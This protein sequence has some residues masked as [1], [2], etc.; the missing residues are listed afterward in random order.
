MLRRAFVLICVLSCTSCALKQRIGQELDRNPLKIQGRYEMVSMDVSICGKFG[1]LPVKSAQEAGVNEVVFGDQIP[2]VK[3]VRQFKAQFIDP[4]LGMQLININDEI[5][6][7][8]NKIRLKSA[9]ANVYG[10]LK[11]S[12]QRRD[13]YLII[14]WSYS[15]DKRLYNWVMK[16]KM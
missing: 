7:Q 2:G 12:H 4:I 3:E 5:I 6:M 8:G 9:R 10:T 14:S 16:K 15:G 11:I 13:T 1:T